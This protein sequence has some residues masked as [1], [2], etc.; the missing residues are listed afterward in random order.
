MARTAQQIID[1]ARDFA[2]EWDKGRIPDGWDAD[3]GQYPVGATCLRFLKTRL[4]TLSRTGYNQC[5]YSVPLVA[6]QATYLFSRQA[7]NVRRAYLYE[8]ATGYEY[9]LQKITQEGLDDEFFGWKRV[10]AE[11]AS[12]YYFIGTKALGIFPI[13]NNT[14]Y[15]LK[16][17][18]DSQV[19]EPSAPSDIIAPL[20]DDS[21]TL[22]LDTDG[23]AASALPEEFN[24]TLSYGVAADICIA[25]NDWSKAGY[26][27]K[28]FKEG[29]DN[30]S[31]DVL[32]RQTPDNDV[33][34]LD[35]RGRNHR[36]PLGMYL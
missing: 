29:M 12:H 14:R 31:A 10:R 18:A 30:L 33:F 20:Y 8:T 21:N 6:N 7:G 3:D 5:I 17:Q 32:S 36:G 2:Q 28:L 27:N 11:R 23:L 9:P 34:Q 16:L 13:V 35:V 19:V 15:V 22:V 25:M 24:D 26:F 1:N 4:R